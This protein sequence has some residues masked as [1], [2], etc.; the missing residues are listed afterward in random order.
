MGEGLASGVDLPR[1][2]L[3]YSGGCRFCR[4][5]ARVVATLDRRGELALLRL[6]DEETRGLLAAIPVGRRNECWWLVLRDGT[7]VP[8]DGG[9]GV[10]LLTNVSLTLPLSRLLRVLRLSRVVDALDA[11]LARYRRHLGRFV[12]EGPAPRRYP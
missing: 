7:P 1:P 2:V 12:P 8:G 3:L 9:G 5:A 11:L 4:W 10:M 6:A